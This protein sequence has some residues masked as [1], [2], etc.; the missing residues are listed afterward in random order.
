MELSASEHCSQSRV[1]IDVESY[2]CKVS[3]CCLNTY[4]INKGHV[5]HKNL[6]NQR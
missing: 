6:T 2:I 4:L 1:S 3:S 5:V